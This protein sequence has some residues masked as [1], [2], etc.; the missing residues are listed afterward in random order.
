M[1]SP[2]ATKDTGASFDGA[3][4]RGAHGPAPIQSGP[5][6]W[7]TPLF[8]LLAC[9]GPI[10]LWLAIFFTAERVEVEPPRIGVPVSWLEE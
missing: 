6:V 8:F 5:L 3:P 9:G 2:A 1:G 7:L 4:I 10:W